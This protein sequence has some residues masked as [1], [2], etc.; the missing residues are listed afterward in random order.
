M[1]SASLLAVALVTGTFVPTESA[2]A[3]P[4]ETRD[5]L[6]PLVSAPLK[7]DKS[8]TP[9]GDFSQLAEAAQL[10]F[11]TK[12]EALKA[13]SGGNSFD[14]G[15]SKLEKRTEFA[16]I[17]LNADGTH[18]AQMTQGPVNV[19]V[20]GKWEPSST[21]LAHDDKVG[22]GVEQNPLKPRFADRANN[23]K[24]FSVSNNGKTVSFSLDG[25]K[26][27]AAQHPTV[28]F[29]DLGA[30]RMAYK[31]VL[32]DIDLHYQV[33][34]NTVK[35]SLVLNSLPSIANSVY[36][37]TVD[38]PNMTLSKDQ[39]GNILIV[40]TDGVQQFVIP[41]PAM[42]DSSAI[43][44]QQNAAYA[45]VQTD[46][47]R[48][49]D[50]WKLIMRPD[51]KWLTDSARIYPVVVDP[52]ITPGGGYSIS[53]YKSDG[54]VAYGTVR[55]GNSRDASTDKY[56]RTVLGWDYSGLSGQHVVDAVV[57]ASCQACSAGNYT[58]GLYTASSF[59]YNGAASYLTTLTMG[60]G[61]GQTVSLSPFANEIARLVNAGC[62]NCEGFMLTGQESAG[63]YTYKQLNTA[64]YANYVGFPSVTGPVAPSPSNGGRGGLRP[65]FNVSASDPA[66][67][68]LNYFYRVSENPN[69]EVAPVYDSGWLN[70]PLFQV[71]AGKLLPGKTYYWKAY[72]RDGYDNWLGV[73]SVRGSAT[74]SF[75]SN[76]SAPTPDRTTA[77][78][79][80]GEV[81][82]TLTP[83][84]SANPVV[85]P[86]GDTPV[87]YRFRVSSG[88]DGNSGAIVTSGW[89]TAPTSGP[90]T[91]TPPV[92]TLQDGG[93]YTWSVIT[94]DGWDSDVPP[95]WLNR[96]KVDLR[97]GASGP[98]PTDSAGPAS[99]NLANGNVNLSFASP[100]VNTVGGPMGL[101]FSY[102]S[103]T[104]A[105]KYHGLTGSYYN[106]LTPGQTSTTTF[107][108]AGKTPLLVRTDPS[109]SFDWGTDSPAPAI[110]TD[111]FLARWAGFIKVPTSG[112]Y[113]FGT[114]HDDGTKVIVNGTTV[115]NQWTS[116]A[117]PLSWGR[118][119]R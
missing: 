21:V 29:V 24:L 38:A 22:W 3:A 79:T 18:T 2:Q 69:P 47:S 99:V 101:S 112:S 93:A 45:M 107:D 113:T 62:I 44:D 34:T 81:V 40:D 26:D 52:S 11:A 41:A 117:A 96:I 23:D 9:K 77:T 68:G 108:F 32:S 105:D 27:A 63:A 57:G 15:T 114:K 39:D 106:A 31:G 53:A 88:A 33:E 16:N 49:G 115:V 46:V 119:C 5:S 78:P 13:P 17:Y 35:E 82:T 10:P 98:S 30:D 95:T 36:T 80:E 51:R 19:K 103:L 111:Y 20:D 43:K 64:L 84:F 1:F 37:W 42:W 109:V 86:N 28:P 25:A 100:T 91:W 74:W 72:V 83:T 50:E 66:G 89:L 8:E 87:K 73:S 118:R 4:R 75:V 60:T 61:S 67:T 110:P 14:P 97:V 54:A 71:P 90:L 58:G 85:D 59:G 12:A 94:D 104:P 102:N 6:P 76:T 92:G 48:N 56:W 116:G 70:G 7:D 65:I 55:L